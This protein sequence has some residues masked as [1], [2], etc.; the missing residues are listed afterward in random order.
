MDGL[1]ILIADPVVYIDD[2]N[3]IY[4][5]TLNQTVA[6]KNNNKF[7]RLQV[8]FSKSINEYVMWSRWG[9][10]GEQGQFAALGDGSLN[11]AKAVF[12]KKFKEKSGLKWEDRLTTPKSGK[13][14]FIERNYEDDDE[15]KEEKEV[16]KKEEDDVPPPESA[17]SKPIQ[18][19]MK[20]IFNAD[21][22]Q[23]VMQAM[24]YDSKK[25]PL[26]KLGDRTL[27][28]GFA[29]L[30][31]LSEL[32]AD[33]TLA[34]SRYGMSIRDAQEELSNRYFT[35]IPHVFGRNRPPILSTFDKIKAEVSLLEAL[36]D[37][38]IANEI[39]KDAKADNDIAELDRQFQGLGMQEMTQ[40]L[41]SIVRSI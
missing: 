6:A 16:V 22:F 5:A 29:T 21:N 4:D 37:M 33:P 13:Y 23:S 15:D 26:G 12:L 28:T 10:V 9:R 39:M 36:T 17:L 11:G 8:L 40:C 14:T 41:S 18:D 35:T 7:Y 32:H 3:V 1:L 38:D 25:L 27:K 34:Q 20:F 31:E 2:D 24:A 19:L 30:K